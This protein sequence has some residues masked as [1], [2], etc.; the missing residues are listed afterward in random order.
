MTVH[1]LHDALTLLPAEL[2]TATDRLRSRPRGKVIR[3]KRWAS[4]AACLVLVLSVTL[5]FGRV[6]LP[7]MMGKT[8]STA[9]APMAAAPMEQA[10]ADVAVPESPAAEAPAM[11]EPGAGPVTGGEAGQSS[12]SRP[13]E[14]KDAEE[15]I[16]IDH[17]HRF[18]TEEQ[19]VEEPVNGYCGNMQVAITVAGEQ[20]LISGTSAVTITDIL[21]NLDYDPD[22]VC[23]CA[24]DI[25]VDTE[26]LTGIQVNPAE[27]FARCER[28][29]AALTREQATIIQ[30]IIDQ[31][32][33]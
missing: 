4:L 29:Q 21:I 10:A 7:G 33:K 16:C 27:G 12:H 26:T 25:I 22:Q 1:D 19:T 32:D 20:Y 3:W 8:E 2:V 13:D 15:E 17:S 24:A 9:Q 31:L 18:V 5:V 28:G 6:L 14:E 11:E 30:E 23:R